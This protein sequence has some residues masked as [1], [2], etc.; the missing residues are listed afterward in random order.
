MRSNHALLY[1][2][3]ND[4]LTVIK[5]TALQMDCISMMGVLVVKP[6]QGLLPRARAAGK[7]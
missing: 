6:A 1:I 2:P 3:G 4:L 7:I 5:T